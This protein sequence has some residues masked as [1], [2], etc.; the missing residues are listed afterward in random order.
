MVEKAV[1]EDLM[2]ISKEKE[3]GRE[4]V[5]SNAWILYNSGTLFFPR[6]RGGGGGD[7][8]TFDSKTFAQPRV[9]RDNAAHQSAISILDYHRASLQCHLL[10][11]RMCFYV[12]FRSRS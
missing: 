6:G 7:A 5:L 12:I 3:G 10:P 2:E 8:F 4:R 1:G 9:F 11:S